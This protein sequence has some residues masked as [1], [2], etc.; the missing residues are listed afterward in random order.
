MALSKIPD[1]GIISR[2]ISLI[3]HQPA[4]NWAANEKAEIFEEDDTGNLF[5]F[6]I[7]L[8]RR[9][10][11]LEAFPSL[12]TKFANKTPSIPNEEPFALE[13]KLAGGDIGLEVR[14]IQFGE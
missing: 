1:D 2:F 8:I 7:K 5:V 3:D 10:N 9:V 4:V 13:S 6:V 14:L 12:A 11:I